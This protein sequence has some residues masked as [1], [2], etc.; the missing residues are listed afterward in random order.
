MRRTI[1]ALL[2]VAMLA[3][4]GC[5]GDD[6]GSGSGEPLTKAEFL[7]QGNAVCAEGNEAIEAAGADLN[8]NSPPEEI[9]A[10]ASETLVPEIQGQID[11]LRDL[12]PPEGDEDQVEAIIDAA[13]EANDQLEED[14]SLVTS[15][16]D[17]F[18]EANDLASEYGL[19]ECAG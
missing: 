11:G 2:A 5:G 4:A 13:Q 19:E 12:S 16:E 7:E 8:Q 10:F 15:N 9:E 14:P 6:E 1:C 17:P 3:L 18:N